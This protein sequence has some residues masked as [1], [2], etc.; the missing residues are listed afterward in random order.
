MAWLAAPLTFFTLLVALGC[1]RRIR[2][3]LPE[4]RP[5]G[6]RHDH[7]LPTPM[8]GLLLGPP[9]AVY[10]A[11]AGMGWLAAATALAWSAGVADDLAKGRGGELGWRLKGVVLL[12]AAACATAAIASTR[13]LS[14]QYLVLL[15]AFLF[16][17]T[18]AFNFLDNTDGVAAALGVVAFLGAGHGSGDALLLAFVY[19]GFLPLNWPV[20]LLFL[21]D[22]GALVLGLLAA[23]ASA[24]H[25]P[26]W[27][28]VLAPVALPLLD[29]VQVIVA[30]LLLGH[31]PWI[32]DRRHLTHMARNLGIPRV[33]IAPL[34]AALAF[35][36]A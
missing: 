30:R 15:C 20:P 2:G 23:T 27:P 21:G 31:P 28:A 33:L 8:A 3:F 1:H 22:S 14:P 36:L 32:G 19:L 26:D 11:T 18:N 5:R 4:D 16:A 13:D 6:G 24:A 9:I 7:A 35:L 29:L 34:F 25:L 12:A 17:V 10:L